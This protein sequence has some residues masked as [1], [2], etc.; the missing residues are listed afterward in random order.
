VCDGGYLLYI[1][2][3]PAFILAKPTIGTDAQQIG[4]RRSDK[5][6]DELADTVGELGVEFREVRAV[7]GGVNDS[8]RG[9]DQGVTSD[10]RGAL[11]RL[12]IRDAEVN[13][14]RPMGEAHDCS[15][16]WRPYVGSR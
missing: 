13:V 1:L 10:K 7:R 15:N 11:Q 14:K 9:T 3:D 2:N 5:I 4:V 6:T 16:R 8:A 12:G